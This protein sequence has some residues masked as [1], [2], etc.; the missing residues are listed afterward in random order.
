MAGSWIFAYSPW[1]MKTSRWLSAAASIRTTAPP[2][3]GWGS[4]NS[5]SRKFSGPPIWCK[6]TARISRFSSEGGCPDDA[7]GD[8]GSAQRGD[9]ARRVERREAANGEAQ[10]PGGQ[11]GPVGTEPE[12]G[13]D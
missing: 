8:L 3:G 11:E 7:G 5:S 10:R 12:T 6:R 9:A 2:G 13:R 4:G 1:R